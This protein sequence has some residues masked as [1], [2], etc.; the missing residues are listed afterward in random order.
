MSMGQHPVGGAL[1]A[2]LLSLPT[3]SSA[4]WTCHGAGGT[5][6]QQENPP[7]VTP[8]PERIQQPRRATPEFND[9]Q[10]RTQQPSKPPATD[11]SAPSW[12]RS[13]LTYDRVL[14]ELEG[15]YPSINPDSPL[16]DQATLDRVVAAMKRRRELGMNEVAALQAAT[17][18]V[19]TQP[20]T[21]PAPPV[22]ATTYKMP[23]DS[24]L[25]TALRGVL[26]G[27]AISLACFVLLKML[28]FLSRSAGHVTRKAADVIDNTSAHDIARAAGG[29]AGVAQKKTSGLLEAFRAGKEEKL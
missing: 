21:V 12:E 3:A 18:D 9:S 28:G 29:M 10:R 24:R 11:Y 2:A 19:F 26:G 8:A 7:C 5:S 27:L 6:W 1:L 4:V 22:P 16:Y 15:R 25:E 13:P 17:A 20:N 23:S 14:S